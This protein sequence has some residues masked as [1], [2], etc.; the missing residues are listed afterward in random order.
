MPPS[1]R[2]PRRRAPGSVSRL[3]AC[4]AR[5][6][7]GAG[8]TLPRRG[9]RGLPWGTG[10]GLRGP[11]G[12]P[13]RGREGKEAR[14]GVCG[15]GFCFTLWD[16]GVAEQAGQ[17]GWRSLTLRCRLSAARARLPA[18]RHGRGR[19][20]GTRLAPA[21]RASGTCSGVSQPGVTYLWCPPHRQG[22]T[23]EVQDRR[24]PAAPPSAFRLS[25]RVAAARGC[26]LRNNQR[27]HRLSFACPELAKSATV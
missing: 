8:A 21:R 2:S 10:V 24:P 18:A 17:R 19:R 7:G 5:R 13:V 26:V 16:A 9:W 27:C 23:V 1:L 3:R 6:G 12:P 15:G 20:P 14:E 25:C 22:C 4:G 11:A